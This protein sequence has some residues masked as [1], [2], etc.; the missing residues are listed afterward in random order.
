MLFHLS[1]SLSGVSSFT[2]SR[3]SLYG[4]NSHGAISTPSVTRSSISRLISSESTSAVRMSGM[5]SLSVA[6]RLTIIFMS[7]LLASSRMSKS[8]SKARMTYFLALISPFELKSSRV[9]NANRNTSRITAEKPPTRRRDQP[10]IQ[11]CTNEMRRPNMTTSIPML[12]ALFHFQMACPGELLK[13]MSGKNARA[14]HA[15]APG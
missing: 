1:R 11:S 15:K 3:D 2:L 14:R 13:G 10:G 5:H 4:M 6:G 12:T 9:P 7:S 8:S